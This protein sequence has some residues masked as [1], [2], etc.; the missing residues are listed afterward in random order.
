M[1]MYGTNSLRNEQKSSFISLFGVQILLFFTMK[2]QK[3]KIYYRFSLNFKRC[4]IKIIFRQ[5]KGNDN[6]EI[7]QIISLI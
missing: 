2:I 7:F 5:N 3:K 6:E 4:N 1:I